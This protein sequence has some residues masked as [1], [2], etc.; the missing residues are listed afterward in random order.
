MYTT[1]SGLIAL[2]LLRRSEDPERV[3][4]AVL[5]AVMWDLATDKYQ[6]ASA[7]RAE[8][9]A[10]LRIKGHDLPRFIQ[11]LAK[12]GFLT[13]TTEPLRQRQ[14]S[15]RPALHYRVSSAKVRGYHRGDDTRQ[16]VNA[17]LR[18][19]KGGRWSPADLVMHYF[20]FDE[21]EKN[22]SVVDACRSAARPP[23][24]VAAI[25]TRQFGLPL[26]DAALL[27]HLVGLSHPTGEAKAFFA[28]LYHD[29]TL[30]RMSVSR[31]LDRLSKHGLVRK[32]SLRR[33]SLEMRLT[34]EHE[35]IRQAIWRLGKTPGSLLYRL[36]FGHRDQDG[37]GLF[38]ARP[39][40]AESSSRLSVDLAAE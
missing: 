24:G 17:L 36:T 33:G 23:F 19:A 32:S 28:D 31:G 13:V 21:H 1:T 15:G 26:S 27:I 29:T 7:S 10:A 22:P 11:H 25:I 5:A 14:G 35:V 8:L 34:V 16:D 37:A 30:G 20:A 18:S 38:L 12:S 4:A 3:G 6:S 40:P 39:V 9:M 2:A